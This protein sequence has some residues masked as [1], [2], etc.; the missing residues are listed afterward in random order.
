MSDNRIFLRRVI[1]ATFAVLLM[2]CGFLLFG[3]AI[4]FFLLIFGA[5]LF[6]V[7]LRAGT[8]FLKEKAN[9]P[10]GLGV[11]ITTLVF[12]GVLAGIIILI[13]PRVSEQVKEMK[14]AI[15]Q[16]ISDVR[17][18]LMEYEWGRVVIENIEGDAADQGEGGDEEENGGG[19]FPDGG[20]IVERAP[21]FFSSTI[22]VISDFLILLVLGIFFAVSPRLY[23]Q[24]VVVLVSPQFRPRLEDV[25]Y[26]LYFVLKSWL[27]G[28]FMAMLFVGV[29]SAIGLMILG[30]PMALALGF[31]A[32]LLDFIPT[33]GPI[34]AAVPA[35]LIAFIQGP[36][37]A[38]W[39]AIIYFVVQSI[40]SYVLVPLIYKKTVSI[41]PVIT[42]GSLVLFGI[43]AGPLGIILATPLVAAIQ[44]IIK[45]LYI[46]D[47]LE[48]DLNKESENSFESRM[49]RIDT[50]K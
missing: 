28:K 5:I 42:L 47:Y 41:S 15:P 38:L 9:V 17:E 25:M 14:E 32:F 49:E 2:V 21:G 36:M 22:G 40:E 20:Q 3:Y 34:I 30:V 45:E 31:I 39:V 37:T 33:I 8:N 44:V 48:S 50:S 16:A 11:A 7:M 46:K 26:K 18:D 19:F 4:Q 27:L 6:A 13:I 10:D 23:V 35:I 43:L 1:V 24:G 12:V 29:G